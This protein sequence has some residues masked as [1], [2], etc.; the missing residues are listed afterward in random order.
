[1]PT[2]RIT[3]I[4]DNLY[5]EI[6]RSA[7]AEN[8]SVSRQVAF[9]LKDYV[10]KRHLL[11]KTKTSAQVLLELSGTWEDQRMAEEIVREIKKSRRNSRNLSEGL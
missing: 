11:S 8:R 9:M 6:K 7:A 2:I 10:A 1:M 4:D 5:E 3:E